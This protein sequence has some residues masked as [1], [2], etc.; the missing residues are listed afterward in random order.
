MPYVPKARHSATAPYTSER[1]LRPLGS[2]HVLQL[3]RSFLQVARSYSE[4][5]RSIPLN[6]YSHQAQAPHLV[7][8]SETIICVSVFYRSGEALAA[9]ELQL[10]TNGH[11]QGAAKSVKLHSASDVDS[12]LNMSKERHILLWLKETH[13]R[14]RSVERDC[15][16]HI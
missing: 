10:K 4:E 6:P 14:A 7:S 13:Q 2:I 8:P 11:P 3:P 16:R 5:T 12:C 1:T 15:L 9:D